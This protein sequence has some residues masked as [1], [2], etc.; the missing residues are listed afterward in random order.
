MVYKHLLRACTDASDDELLNGIDSGDLLGRI[1]EDGGDSIR[2]SDLT[3]ALDR[4][5]QLQAKLDIRPPVLTY[6]AQRRRVFLADRAF[7]FYRKYGAAAWPWQDDSTL[8]SAIANAPA[9]EM[10][11]LFDDVIW[12][13]E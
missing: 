12:D 11:T 2:Q 7:L 4:I 5:A 3:Q 8:D 13:N 6:E 1:Q 9:G 10:L